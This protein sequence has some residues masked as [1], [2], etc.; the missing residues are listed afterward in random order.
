MFFNF[1][2]FSKKLYLRSKTFWGLVMND[3]IIWA[4]SWEKTLFLE[5]SLVLYTVWANSEGSGETARMPMWRG[6]VSHEAG[7]SEPTNEKMTLVSCVLCSF[8]RACAAIQWDQISGSL[9]ERIAK[10]Q[11]RLRGCG[12]LPSPSLF[13]CAISTF[14]T[15]T[16]SFV[17]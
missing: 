13:A 3:L 16:G 10:A 17:L 7:S 11:A 2:G 14:F 8:K 5:L 4:D 9:C 15:W 6:S 1:Q 12:G